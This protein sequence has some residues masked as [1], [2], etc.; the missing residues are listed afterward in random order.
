M[1]RISTL[2]MAL[3]LVSSASAFKVPTFNLKTGGAVKKSAPVVPDEELP[4]TERLGGIGVS[5]P[6]DAGFDPLGFAGRADRAE[7]VKYREAELKHGRVAMLAVPGFLL[8]EDF[9][10]LFNTLP[11][12]EFGIFAMQDTVEQPFFQPVLLAGLAVVAAIE[13]STFGGWAKPEGS[14]GSSDST[15]FKMDPD[16][17]PGSFAMRG[18]WSAENLSPDAFAKK[19]LSE[20]NNGRLAMIAIFIIVLQELITKE[21]AELLDA[22]ILQAIADS[23]K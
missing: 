4:L 12:W 1:S 8:S 11:K 7:M 18:P 16:Y 21:P 13:S 22:D 5:A 20:L 2:V 15:F 3:A 9:H 10:P 17:V 23:A 19:Q 14:V 6:F